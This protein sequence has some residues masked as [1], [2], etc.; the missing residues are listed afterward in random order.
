MKQYRWLILLGAVTFVLGVVAMFPAR[1]AYNL[2][3]PSGIHVSGISGTLWRGTVQEA[4]LSSVYISDVSWQF[5][6]GA[7]FRGELGYA[8]EASPAGGFA[9]AS[10]GVGFGKITLRNFEGGLAIAAIQSVIATPGIEGTTRLDFPLIRLENGFPTAADGTVEVR[11]LVARGL[12]QAPIG[13][14]RAVLASSD[15]SISGSIED[16]DAVL[17]IAGSLR[18]GADRNYLL[19]GLVAPTAETPDRIVNQLRFLGSPNERGQRQFRF[20]GR[21]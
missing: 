13:D 21:L 11:G 9:K 20:E 12:S 16:L 14:F 8:V 4:E 10:V 17:D 3:S 5:L 1:V 2:L 15:A 6:P 7:L 18:I 19:N